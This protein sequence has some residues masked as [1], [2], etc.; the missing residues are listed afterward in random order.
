MEYS[1]IL[2][3]MASVFYGAQAITVEYGIN[4]FK[5]IKNTSPSFLAAFISIVVS[6]IIFWILLL[7]RGP[8]LNEIKFI[9][10]WPFILAGTLNPAIFRLLYFKSIDE[11]GAGISSA[12]VAANPAIAAIIAIALL[13]EKLTIFTMVGISL[14]I[15][16]GSLIQL[17][18]NT[19][20][21]KNDDLLIKR[22]KETDK[23]DLIYP[24]SAMTFIGS[25]YVFVKFG[26]NIIPNSFIATTVAQTTALVIFLILIIFYKDLR[27]NN[28]ELNSSTLA[29]TLAGV[30]V[31]LGWLSSF[32]AL[33]Y[34]TA[35]TVIPLANIFPL[36]VLIGSY[37]LAKE[38]PKSFKIV[39]AIISIIVGAIIIQIV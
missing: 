30:F 14:I 37:S 9:N 15:F 5:T 11:V 4:K 2:A 21:E 25:S 10:L 13:G 31:A 33:K 7:V 12:I 32:T 27:P 1:A 8:N 26:L 20:N 6:V 29:F 3:M 39:F 35:I 36:I 34:G 19:E 28:I 38:F 18:R 23:E 24:I 22:L 17:L 16:G